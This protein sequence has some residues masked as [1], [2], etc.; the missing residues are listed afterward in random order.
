MM[1]YF[2][3]LALLPFSALAA[4]IPVDRF[5]QS[6]LESVLR[7]IPEAFEKS[8][9]MTT[10]VRKFFSFPKTE[11][12]FKISC[13]ADHFRSSPIPSNSE[14]K[15]NV[16]GDKKGDEI[17]I[18]IT[19]A[20]VVGNLFAVMPVTSNEVRKVYST[21]R[22]YGQAYA[23]NYRE[24]FRYIFSCSQKSCDLSVSTKEAP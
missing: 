23:G 24:L 18:K 22:I 3:I 2:G 6:K 5:D 19:D 16:S 20:A 8:E 14:C 4:S 9:D 12:D 13:V 11:S 15:L 10:H 17:Q 7:R 1:K 21:E